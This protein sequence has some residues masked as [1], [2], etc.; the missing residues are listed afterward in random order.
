M[1]RQIITAEDVRP[2]KILFDNLCLDPDL[3]VDRQ[4]EDLTEDLFAAGFPNGCKLAVD[5]F[6]GYMN[7]NGKFCVSLSQH[8]DWWDSFAERRFATIGEIR[9]AVLDLA[10]IARNRRERYLF[11]GIE[12]G[13]DRVW[14][15]ELVLDPE[16]APALQPNLRKPVLF[17]AP[18]WSR[19]LTVGWSNPSSPD[20]EFI[21]ALDR[22]PDNWEFPHAEI[23]ALE[24]GYRP[25][26]WEPIAERRCGT[27]G[28]LRA[29][30]DEFARLAKNL[31]E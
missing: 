5:W 30:V 25:K 20:G 11:G 17:M 8:P 12:I 9:P 21:V 2:A 18:V 23:P 4:L 15:N 24:R 10:E 19:V 28:D 26:N 16:T 6:G 29:T 27:V 1:K 13:A 7:P 31:S 14:I 3:P 22:V